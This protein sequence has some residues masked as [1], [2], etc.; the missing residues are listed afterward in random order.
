MHQ[1]IIIEDEIFCLDTKSDRAEAAAALRDA[2]ISRA[3]VWRG[4]PE[5]N[6]APEGRDFGD[7]GQ[8][9]TGMT[10]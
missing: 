5:G 2:G 4:G 9:H 6:E 1:F 8:F 10:A 3:S 7:D